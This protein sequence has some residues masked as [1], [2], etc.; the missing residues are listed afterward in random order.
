MVRTSGFSPCRVIT[1]LGGILKTDMHYVYVLQSLKDYNTYI[2]YTSN[3]RKR[4]KEHNLGKTK[5]LKHRTPF[6]LIYYEA[7]LNKTD[8]RKREIELKRN[9]SKKRE[10]FR[11]IKKSLI[12]PP[13]SS[14]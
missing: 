13:S 14:G 10:L 3:L 12:V 7:F 8:A 9:S 5:S 4:F 6:K 1:P 2:G 11:N